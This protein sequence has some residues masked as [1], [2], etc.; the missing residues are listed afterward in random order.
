MC[1]TLILLFIATHATP[2]L[3]VM[4]NTTNIKSSDSESVIMMYE[5]RVLNSSLTSQETDNVEDSTSYISALSYPAPHRV[6]K[7]SVYAALSAQD[8]SSLS[9]VDVPFRNT[10]IIL[11]LLAKNCLIGLTYIVAQHNLFKVKER[12]IYEK[13]AAIVDAHEATYHVHEIIDLDDDALSCGWLVSGS[14]PPETIETNRKERIVDSDLLS[15]LHLQ[16]PNRE[17]KTLSNSS[18]VAKLSYWSATAMDEDMTPLAT[19]VILL[20][21]FIISAV[22]PYVKQRFP[23]SP[24]AGFIKRIE[25]NENYRHHHNGS[26]FVHLLD[27]LNGTNQTIYPPQGNSVEG[28]YLMR[29]RDARRRWRYSL[30]LIEKVSRQELPFAVLHIKIEERTGRSVLTFAVTRYTTVEVYSVT[31]GSYVGYTFTECTGQEIIISDG[32]SQDGLYVQL[33]C[34]NV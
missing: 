31:N 33:N 9:T 17:E 6:G 14:S 30:Q 26:L 15:T 22:A 4:N 28:W 16:T 12:K 24:L 7:V 8:T 11:A 25:R 13:L 32:E 5:T 1:F 34:R 3:A 27:L 20:I 21:I 2:A 23:S 29:Y 19:V 18:F 10:S